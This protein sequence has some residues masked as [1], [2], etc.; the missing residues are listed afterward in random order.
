MKTAA[1]STE[2]RQQAADCHLICPDCF[3]EVPE[4]QVIRDLLPEWGIFNACPA[5]SVGSPS[6]EWKEGRHS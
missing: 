6:K 2:N 1:P 5:C 3:A 4:R